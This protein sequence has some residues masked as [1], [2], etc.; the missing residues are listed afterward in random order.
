MAKEEY[1]PYNKEPK[2]VSISHQGENN[3]LAIASLILGVLSILFYFLR[4][5]QELLQGIWHDP[6]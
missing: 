4:P 1:N 5:Y 6:V 2:S 3:N